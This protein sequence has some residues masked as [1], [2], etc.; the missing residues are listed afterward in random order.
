[1]FRRAIAIAVVACMLTTASAPAFPTALA[2]ATAAPQVAFVQISPVMPPISPV[3]PP[4]S[5]VAGLPN[6]GKL[7]PIRPVLPFPWYPGGYLPYYGYGYQ[8]PPVVVVQVPTPVQSATQ[9][10]ERT[11][12]ISNEFPATLVLEFPAAAEVWVN[13]EK[14]AEEPSSEWTL[15]SPVLKPGEEYT[16]KVK[17]RWKAGGKTIEAERVIAVPGG[18][19]SRAIVL[20]GT[21]IKE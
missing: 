14:S 9:P 20:S 10:P 16:F 12:I 15:T 4:I 11:V 3:M 8:Q 6:L 18:K 13:G 7:R 5:P 2:R 17:A 19:R 1:M 21:E